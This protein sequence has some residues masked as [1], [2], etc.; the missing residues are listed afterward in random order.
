MA[1]AAQVIKAALQKIIVQ[2]SESNFEASEYADAILTLN[3]MM[4]EYDAD[5]VKLGY[6]EITALN[7]QVTVPVGALRSVIYNLA[8]SLADEYGVSVTPSLASIA[9][10]SERVMRQIGLNLGETAYPSTLTR[11]SGNYYYNS[12]FTNPYYPC[13]ETEILAE[14]TGSIAVETGTAEA[15][16]GS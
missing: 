9:A 5:G 16:D 13:S 2:A 14:T 15:I 6:T 11:G 3:N 1:S 12:S 10:T 7:E 4:F 8:L